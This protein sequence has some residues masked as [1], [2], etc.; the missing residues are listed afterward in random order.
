MNEVDFKNEKDLEKK[1]RRLETFR[2][3]SKKYYFK[4]RDKV[5]ERIKIYNLK[6]Q[7]NLAIL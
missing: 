1:Q 5:I 3:S 7:I 4:N 6:K 2:K